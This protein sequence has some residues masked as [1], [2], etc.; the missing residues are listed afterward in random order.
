[1]KAPL[2]VPASMRTAAMGFPPFLCVVWEIFESCS[3]CAT[4][5]SEAVVVPVL[6]VHQRQAAAC[7]LLGSRAADVALGQRDL[8][9]QVVLRIRVAQGFFEADA[10]FAVEVVER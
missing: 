10:A 3:R 4:S 1:M 7:P 9:T 8:E 5:R 2:R 6:L